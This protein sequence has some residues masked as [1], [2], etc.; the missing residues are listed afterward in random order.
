MDRLLHTSQKQ[1]FFLSY[2]ANILYKILELPVEELEEYIEKKI[3][4]NPFLEKNYKSSNI[5]K[6]PIDLDVFRADL[7]HHLAQ[8]PCLVQPIS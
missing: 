1:T 6:I 7:R 3:D 2:K 8:F 4:K 5:K